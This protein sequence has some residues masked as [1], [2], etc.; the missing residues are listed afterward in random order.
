[1]QSLGIDLNNALLF[2]AAFLGGALNAVA[3]GG[4]FL[5]LPALVF[6]GIS[7]TSANAT[8]TLALLSGYIASA[9]ALRRDIQPLPALSIQW[10]VVLS[11]M[12]GAIGA[13]LLMLTPDTTFRHLIPWLLLLATCLFAAGPVFASRSTYRA[14]HAFIAGAGIV[15]VA[16]YGGYFNGGLGILLLALFGLLGN[17][18]IQAA[19]GLK[20]LVS[21]VLTAL[22]VALY[23][24]GGLI[25]WQ[26]AGVMTLGAVLGGHYGAKA[27]R[28]VP[29]TLLRL[30]IVVTG[31]LMSALFFRSRI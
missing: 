20:N 24:G 29:A 26:E 18:H 19:N 31:L 28:H 25:A 12:G 21:A 7:P 22:A 8:G 2:T 9:W 6:T 30:G 13:W 1:M 16:V 17:A 4:S 10:V 15:G 11:L 5:T 3:G 14:P 27:M 23:I